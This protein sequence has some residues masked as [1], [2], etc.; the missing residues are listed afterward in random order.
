ML[1]SEKWK[2]DDVCQL[3]FLKEGVDTEVDLY[4]RGDARPLPCSYP[5]HLLPSP[6][7]V[8]VLLQVSSL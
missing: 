1:V 7:Y 5:L 6:T 3:R 8:S 4:R 2:M